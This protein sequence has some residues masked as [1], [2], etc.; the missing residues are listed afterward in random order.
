MNN[1]FLFYYLYNHFLF[2]LF[3]VLFMYNYKSYMF[4]W[5]MLL[6]S[7][8]SVPFSV[9]LDW[10]SI[11]FS[12][13]VLFISGNVFFFARYY[14]AQDL[15]YYRFIWLLSMFVLSMNI[16]IMSGSLLTLLIGW[17]G[18][19][20]TSFGLI[21]YYQSKESLSS[22]FLTMLIN[23][24]GDILIMSSLFYFVTLGHTFFCNFQTMPYIIFFLLGLA[25]LTKSAQYPFSVWLPAAM[26]AP[27]PVSALVHSSTLVTAGV[28]V[29]IRLTSSGLVYED[30]SSMLIFCG[31]VTSFIG[32]SCALLEYDLKKLI[33]LSTLSQ[34]GVMVF[35]LGMNLY[36][37][38][39]L[40]LFT[41]AMFKALL[42]L[43]AGC[44]LMMSY[45][46]QDIR[47][48]GNVLK[49]NPMLLIM[50]NISAFCLMGFTVLSGFYSKHV[51]LSM[52][53]CSN[54]YSFS[55]LLMLASTGLTTI[56]MIRLLKC[57]NWG[58]GG[59][60]LVSKL[61]G[62][63]FWLPLVMMFLGS[64]FT[65]WLFSSLNISVV[66]L[67]YAP[68]YTEYLMNMILFLGVF[69]GSTITMRKGTIFL[70]SMYFLSPF[71]Y[72]MPSLYYKVSKEMVA[73]DKGWL[74]YYFVANKINKLAKKSTLT[75]WPQTSL[76]FQQSAYLS[77]S[78]I[79][80]L[81]YLL[82]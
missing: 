21:I 69:L 27:T 25:A 10:V 9:L 45:G 53:W 30:L 8:I 43:A 73:L 76:N 56:Y 81:W 29:L 14:M 75:F 41:H 58:L 28:F 48:L 79:F 24:M 35:C 52:M 12:A 46:V 62:G 61:P 26:A 39:L 60:V 38:A 16:L 80:F 47:L 3:M 37:L 2:M 72:S 19:G 65:G 23:R 34:L 78:C 11:S 6:V 4:S 40:H 7:S 32:G 20:V 54:L 64:M 42:F 66:T 63:V 33:A 74:E 44:V 57:I 1:G 55:M 5:E 68:T 31:S 17:D 18:L 51:I 15:F 49:T 67:A 22:G 71:W 70:S 82:K 36:S 59:V 50:M 77:F 13:L